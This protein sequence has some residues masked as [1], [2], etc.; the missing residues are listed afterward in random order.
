MKF[1]QDCGRD[2]ICL[3]WHLTMPCT[4]TISECSQA[5]SF[6]C[7]TGQ[8][9]LNPASLSCLYH[10]VPVQKERSSIR[11]D[12]CPVR[13]STFSLS[14]VGFQSY[15]E[16]THLKQEKERERVKRRK[17]LHGQGL[18]RQSQRRN[19]KL[20]LCWH[21]GFLAEGFSES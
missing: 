13:V 6:G 10:R 21:W 17:G 14:T 20:P 3:L 7:I 8:G 9:I 11:T 1:A 15:F 16:S 2:L 4:I 18:S 19:L 5:C 12:A